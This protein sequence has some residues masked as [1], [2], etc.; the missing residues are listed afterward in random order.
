MSPPPI[1]RTVAE[2]NRE[3]LTAALRT[4]FGDILVTSL[5]IADTVVGTAT[6]VRIRVTYDGP[7][8]AAGLPQSLIVKAGFRDGGQQH[9]FHAELYAYRDL[10]A[11]MR[12]N[13]PRCYFAA[14][15][16]S[17]GATILV[18]EDLADKNVCFCTPLR[19]LT[20]AQAASFLDLQARYHAAWLGR[21]ELHDDGELGHVRRWVS[22][23]LI[24]QM[25]A[26]L[27]PEYWNACLALPRGTVIPG[28]LRDPRRVGLALQRLAEL[29]RNDTQCIVHADAHLANA[30]LEPDGTPG[31]IDWQAARAPWQQDFTYFMVGSLDWLDRR[32][33]ERSLLRGYLARLAAYGAPAPDFE[34]AWLAYRREIIYGFWVF[35]ICPTESQPETIDTACVARFTT[36]AVDHDT[37]WLLQEG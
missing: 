2:I 37:L 24:E 22:G 30:Y 1:P 34:R 35:T 3:W 25:Q 14:I 19:P 21:A 26:T 27:E 33:W 16:P 15:D 6:K 32:T 29:H 31:Y 7:G 4:R 36:A 20:Y 23:P 8:N 17:S 18:L 5:T 9:S 28:A 13:A 11:T 12:A 10:L